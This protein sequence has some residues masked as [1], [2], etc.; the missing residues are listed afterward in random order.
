M[1][2]RLIH[3]A[4]IESRRNEANN[5]QDGGPFGAVI[6]KDGVVIARGHNTVIKD[7][8]PTA[9]AEVNAIREAARVLGTHDLSGTTIYASSEPCPMCLS[10][11]IWANIKEAYFANTR[12]DAEDIGFRDDLIYDFIKSNNSDTNILDLRRIASE[13]ALQVFKDFKNNKE[14][15]MY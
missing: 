10:S 7:A 8:D 9:H 15:N 14:K 3:E 1:N 6:V 11:I 12:K 2:E 4:V 5:Y 13:E